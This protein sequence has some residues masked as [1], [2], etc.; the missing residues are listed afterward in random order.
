M[1][2][3]CPLDKQ[4]FCDSLRNAW[5]YKRN[6]VLNENDRFWCEYSARTQTYPCSKMHAGV[7]S[8]V[9]SSYVPTKGVHEHKVM[10]RVMSSYVQVMSKLCPS[11]V[12]AKVMYQVMSKV[13][14]KLC[15][16]YVPTQKFNI[17]NIVWGSEYQK[18]WFHWILG[19]PSFKTLV[20]WL[21]VRCASGV[22]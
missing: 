6:V 22:V 8:G 10:Y 4:F 20:L 13:M 14:S 11:Y 17:R 1:D 16:S 12:Q 7:M 5:K 9:M 15:P 3:V 18:P 2:S 19:F 21:F